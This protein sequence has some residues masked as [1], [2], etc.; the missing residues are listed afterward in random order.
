M[1]LIRSTA[2]IDEARHI[3]SML[4]AAGLSPTVLGRDV[5]DDHDD[6]IRVLVPPDE[7]GIAVA[8]LSR[9]ADSSLAPLPPQQC[10]DCGEPLDPILR[11]CVSCYDKADQRQIPRAAA[12]DPLL[13]AEFDRLTGTLTRRHRWQVLAARF[14]ALAL[15]SWLLDSV[16]PFVVGIN[17]LS[18][19]PRLPVQLDAHGLTLGTQRLLWEDLGE[20]QVEP[21]VIRWRLR[22]GSHGEVL[23][24]IRYDHRK[25]LSEAIEARL[26]P[27]LPERDASAEQAVRALIDRSP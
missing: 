8:T 21:R 27:Q 11:M 9:Q 10:T 23:V 6:S 1:V 3:A 24:N 16:I 22:D 12:P 4:R 25:E 26:H 19:L 17:L 2:T 7:I 20:L 5:D 14:A 13:R 18:L 15:V